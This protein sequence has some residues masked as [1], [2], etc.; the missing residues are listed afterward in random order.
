MILTVGFL[1]RSFITLRKFSS[2]FRLLKFLSEWIFNC[3]K[4]FLCIYWIVYGT[5]ILVCWY[6]QNTIVYWEC[7]TNFAA[8]VIAVATP[9]VMMY[10]PFYIL[11][12]FIANILLRIFI[13][14]F[15]KDVSV[16][17]L[18]ISSFVIRF[19]AGLNNWNIFFSLFWRCLCI[20]LYI[21][22]CLSRRRQWH[23]WPLTW[24]IMDGAAW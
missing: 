7:W 16:V 13:S 10:Y 23:L 20:I 22:G 1:Q 17:L 9:L 11:R 14:V 3:S 5:R 24:K 2:I 19:Q 21:L 4:C 6:N 15:L 12:G 18:E 8:A